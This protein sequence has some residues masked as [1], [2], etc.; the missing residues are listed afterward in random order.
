MQGESREA[1]CYCA[2][3]AKIGVTSARKVKMETSQR[4]EAPREAGGWAVPRPQLP[5]SPVGTSMLLSSK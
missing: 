1:M 2:R 5:N 4:N 3:S